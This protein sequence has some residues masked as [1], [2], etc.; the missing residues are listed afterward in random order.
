MT[1]ET[2][3]APGL[4]AAAAHHGNVGVLGAAAL[5]T[6]GMVGS[7]YFLLPATMA[8]V[9][10]ISILGWLAATVAALAV[11]AVFA[12]L[13]RATPQATGLE[14][15][16]E[17]GLGPFFGVQ[18]TVTYW[19]S[20]WFGLVAVPLAVAGAVGFLVPALAGQQARLAVT[21]ASI[22]LA[23]AVSWLG[24]RSVARVEGLTLGIGLLPV[25][26][27]ATFG[28][29]AFHPSVFL[30][31]WNPQGLSAGSAVGAS[32]L[33]AFYAFLGVECAAAAAG[34]VRDPARNVPRATLLGVAAAA[35][36]YIASTT[37]LM[38]ILP[39]TVLAKSQAPFADAAQASFGLGLAGVIAICAVLRAQG[40]LTGFTLLTSETTRNAADAG[41]FL[42]WYRTR[43]GER[44]SPVNLL[45][46]GVLI[47][48]VA[49]GTA[50]PT[51]AQQFTTVVNVSVILSLYCYGIVSASLMRL[52]SGLSPARRAVAL[53]TAAVTMACAVALTVT[54]KPAELA[55]SAV[56]PVAAGLLYL[57]LRRR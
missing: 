23:V 47:S 57:W 9:G 2:S 43:P 53:V 38:G 26:L 6:G 45:T 18:I 55:L 15:Y 17:A 4:A 27:A 11:A 48:L 22:W 5:V 20:N 8:A 39:A 25:L 46:V 19:A 10:S 33:S 49:V 21:L 41:A 3:D 16:A 1:T 56:P 31:S 24:P 30:A 50:T 34:V 51:L 54:A 7:G 35:L 44:A 36:V 12:Q 28:W 40:C 29:L 42:A 52:S 37:V 14:S 13:G 32:A